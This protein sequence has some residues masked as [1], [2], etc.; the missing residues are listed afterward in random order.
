MQATIPSAADRKPID[1]KKGLTKVEPVTPPKVYTA[2]DAVG[3]LAE[4]M[5]NQYPPGEVPDSVKLA[6]ARAAVSNPPQ[7]QQPLHEDPFHPTP[8]DTPRPVQYLPHP[9]PM[10]QVASQPLYQIPAYQAPPNPPPAPAQPTP[11]VAT[12]LAQ[13]QAQALAMQAAVPQQQVVPI[14]P[15]PGMVQ[16]QAKDEVRE[17][18]DS[19]LRVTLTLQDGTFTLPATAV[20]ETQLSVFVFFPDDPGSVTFVPK[21]GTQLQISVDRGGEYKSWDVYYP[22]TYVTVGELAQTMVAFIKAED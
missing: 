9:P 15:P 18:L 8:E 14:T 13:A 19:R 12:P 10:Q 16:E 20:R 1:F 5:A 6:Q 22:G 2:K 3:Q 17:F 21:P 4:H 7:V 11:R